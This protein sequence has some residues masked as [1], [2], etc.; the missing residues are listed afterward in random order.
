MMTSREWMCVLTIL[1]TLSIAGAEFTPSAQLQK[2]V[3]FRNGVFSRECTNPVRFCTIGF[4]L[5]EPYQPGHVLTFEYRAAQPE[6]LEYV[7]CVLYGKGRKECFFGFPPSGEWR[8]ARV[9]FVRMGRKD[10][11]PG[12]ML[13]RVHIYGR[14]NDRDPAA[15]MKLEIRDLRMF[16]DRSVDP[17][18][19]IR[20]SL[21]RL[22]HC[23]E[24]VISCGSLP[25]GG[26]GNLL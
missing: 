18:A 17:L 8:T 21:Y 16:E 7:A 19:G 2:G 12:E 20:Q 13:E 14:I 3:T 10:F 9:P 22:F 26:K 1:L 25:A 5:Q 6:K 23:G 11:Q 4:R 15:P 24:R